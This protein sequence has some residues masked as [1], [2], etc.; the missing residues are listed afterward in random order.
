LNNLLKVCILIHARSLLLFTLGYIF[1]EC[2]LIFDYN[3]N[4]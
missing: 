2:F 4:L 1:D 3:F